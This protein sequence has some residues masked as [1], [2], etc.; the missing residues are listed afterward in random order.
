VSLRASTVGGAVQVPPGYTRVG[1]TYR[2]PG[3]TTGD[4]IEIDA[5]LVFGQIRLVEQ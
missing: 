3:F 4:H 1:S 5:S 2:S